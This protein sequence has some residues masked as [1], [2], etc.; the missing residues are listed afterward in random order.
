MAFRSDTG[1]LADERNPGG[2]KVI[3]DIHY[4]HKRAIKAVQSTV[5]K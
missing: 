2:R 5:A 4:Y 3:N 1:F